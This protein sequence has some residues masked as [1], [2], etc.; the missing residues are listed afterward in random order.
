MFQYENNFVKSLHTATEQGRL[1]IKVFF[2]YIGGNI[3]RLGY[4]KRGESWVTIA[5]MKH[6]DQ[7]NLGRSLIFSLCSHT[8]VH[9][10]RKSWQDLK[11]LWR[12]ELMQRPWRGVAYWLAHHG[13]LSLSSYKTEDHSPGVA[14]PAIT[15]TLPCQSLV[16]KIFPS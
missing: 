15:C 5:V 16:R 10:Q 2:Q 1:Q 8:T 6:S 13:L 14:L 7:S 4:N 12:Q 9:H 3:R 11:Q